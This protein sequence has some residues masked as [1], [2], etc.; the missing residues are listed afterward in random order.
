M[1]E[2]KKFILSHPDWETILKEPPYN[3]SISRDNDFIIFKYFQ[4]LSDFSLKIVREAR[5]IIFYEPTWE[6][7]CH[8]FDKFGNYGESYCPEIDWNSALVQEKIDGSLIK[9]WK[10]NG[11]WHISTNGAIDAYKSSLLDTDKYKTFGELFDSIIKNYPNFYRDLWDGFTYM[12]ELVS[13][14][15]RVVVPYDKPDI[16]LLGARNMASDSEINPFM[17]KAYCQ[18]LQNIKIP[19]TYSMQ[20]LEEVQNAANALGWDEEGF[21][22]KDIKYNRVKIKSP[23]WIEAHYVRGN[24]IITTEAII[25]IIKQHEEEEFLIYAQ[26]KKDRLYEIK[27]YIE[28]FKYLLALEFVGLYASCENKTKKEFS[29]V[30]TSQNCGLDTPLLYKMFDYIEFTGCCIK[31]ASEA[32]V[33]N[34]IQRYST[35]KIK[36]II[37]KRFENL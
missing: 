30:V 4:G 27:K 14:Y 37:V 7:V 10:F 19:K 36:E 33:D 32:I 22:V 29:K 21:V 2:L 8:P 1:L 20:T 35:E 18:S 9:V 25:N 15:N 23:Q 3:L 13:P 12:F 24:N 17:L 16:Y 31:D 34:V 6:C 26:D 5:G 28:D 11:E